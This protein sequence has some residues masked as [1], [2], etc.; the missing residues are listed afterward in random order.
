MALTTIA[1]MA[2]STAPACALSDCIAGVG[3]MGGGGGYGAGSVERGE[4]LYIPHRAMLCLSKPPVG[5]SFRHCCCSS[6]F[7]QC[8]REDWDTQMVV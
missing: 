6:V 1:I 4:P 7:P 5:F 2:V 8:Q 3:V